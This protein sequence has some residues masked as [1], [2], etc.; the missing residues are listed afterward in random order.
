MAMLVAGV[1]MAAVSL[2]MTVISPRLAGLA[3]RLPRWARVTDPEGVTGG[4]LPLR[5]DAR[6]LALGAA[7]FF[8]PCGFTQAVQIYALSTGD[9]WRA[10]LVL[11][12][13]ALG[14]S[15]ALLAIGGAPALARGPRRET[16]LRLA[17]VAIM[18]FAFVN[19]A[20]ALATLGVAV[21]PKEVL[22]TAVTANVTIVNGVQS[23]T[24]ATDG[25]GYLP[26]HTVVYA[27]MPVRW[28]VTG[29]S[30]GCASALR[31]PTL[32]VPPD[33]IIGLGETEIFEFVLDKPGRVTYR[34]AM[35][36]YSGTMTAIAPPA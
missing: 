19:V 31:A 16:F 30:M 22:P 13:F 4:R 29:T 33:T 1:A 17:G 23:A 21:S 3:P 7:S 32:G 15:P 10:G 34:C 2:Q 14:T 5:R 11:A 36:M 18:A 25:L 26:T 24:L 20:G 12:A 8:V 9:P 6:A 28:A 35:G 27:G